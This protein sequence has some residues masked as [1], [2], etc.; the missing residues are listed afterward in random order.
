MKSYLYIFALLL[1]YSCQLSKQDKTYRYD[2]E[3]FLKNDMILGGTFN[4]DESKM[5]Y[6]SNRSG[7]INAWEVNLKDNS[8]KQLTFSEDKSYFAES[9]FPKDDRIILKSD[10][11]GNEVYHIYIKDL[12][13]HITDVT[14][15]KGATSKFGGWK[16]EEKSFFVVSNKRDRRFFDLYEMDIEN[17]ELKLLYENKK[18]LNLNKISKDYRYLTVTK[19]VTTSSSKLYLIDRVN[20]NIKELSRSDNADYE[21]QFFDLHT[22]YLYYLTDENS[23]F[24]YLIRYNLKSEER[25]VV[26]R[27]NWD[28]WYAYES[29]FGKYHV[30]GINEDGQTKI[31]VID[32]ESSRE[33]MIPT[34]DGSSINKVYV[35]K[36][37]KLLRFSVGSSTS[38]NN[39][40]IYDLKNEQL[41]RLT[42]SMNP[43]INRQ[44]LVDGIN[45]RYKASDD[46][47]IPAILYKPKLA[48]STNKVPALIWVH[49]GPGGQSRLTYNPLI[50]FLSNHGYAI[51]AVNNRGSSGYGKSFA[52]MDDLKH[53][54]VDLRDCIDAKSYLAQLDYVDA[55]NIGIIGS[56]YGGYITM[57]ALSLHPEEF[58]IGVNL[59]GITNL[60]RTL[61]SIPPY[62]EAYRKALYA[63]M[64]NPFTVDSIRLKKMSPLFSADKINKPLFV[65]QG[66]ND[67]R[68]LRAESDDIVNEVREN[69]IA[70]EYLLFEDEGH[71]FRKKENEIKAYDR[72]LKFLDKYLKY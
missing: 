64:G 69:G 4:H 62:W 3:D 8:K 35:S 72:I 40:F 10:E 14:P 27:T 9:Y 59:F 37:E 5:L 58:K 68:V 52:R 48:N 20:G 22:N 31:K 19:A 66:A 49:G 44:D 26:W 65:A 39:I 16:R 63:E 15:W 41:Q 6:S 11:G 46:L 7:V 13:G 43:E 24:T 29:Y 53:G 25:E 23:E 61:K 45:V 2:I 33:V 55:D 50:Q 70:V 18:G 54:D 38:P 57:A 34:I 60:M 67:P 42:E 12:E 28:I 32:T 1:F 51:L 30:I 21:A 17:F 36:S 47:D 56:S 71:G